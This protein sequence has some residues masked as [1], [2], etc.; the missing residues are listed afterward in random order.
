MRLNKTAKC[1][2]VEKHN[3]W[4]AEEVANQLN[5]RKNSANVDIIL[6]L[7]KVRPLHAK[8]IVQIFKH[9]R[10]RKNLIFNAVEKCCRKM[11]WNRQEQ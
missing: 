6:K 4:F 8:W 3:N 1:F 9:L 7:S 5:K 2:I 10:T 11:Q